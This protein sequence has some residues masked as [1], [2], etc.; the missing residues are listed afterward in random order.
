MTVVKARTIK[1]LP[2]GER[3]TGSLLDEA[4]R[5]EL[6]PNA[7]EDDGGRV[8]IRALVFQPH[9]AIPPPPLMSEFR[10]VR[11]ASLRQTD[12]EHFGYTDNCP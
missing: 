3:W 5:S 2:P 7:L 1:P 9:A 10:E 11:R 4:Q 12:V 6:A 8:G